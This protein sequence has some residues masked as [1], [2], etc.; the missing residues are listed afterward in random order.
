M[1]SNSSKGKQHQDTSQY[2]EIYLQTDKTAYYAGETVTGTIFLNMISHY[3]GNQLFLQF[4]GTEATHI[5]KQEQRGDHQENIK[6]SNKNKIIKQSLLVHSWE[7]LS[8]GQFSIPFSFLLPLHLPPSFYQQGHRYFAFLEYQLEAF[9]Q[10]HQDTDPRMKYKQPITLREKILPKTGDLPSH[11]TTQLK[12]C[13]CCKQ[14]SNF[15]KADFEKNFYSPGENAQAIMELNNSGTKLKNLKVV[16]A[17]KQRLELKAKG[18]ILKNVLVKVQQELPGIIKGSN[19]NA[20]TLTIVLPRFPTEMDFQR[21]V[22]RKKPSKSTL[23]KFKENREV[24]TSTTKS[25][26][27]TSTFFLEVSCP[28]NGCCSTLPKAQCPI[29]I[30]SPDFQLP[31]VTAPQNW[32]PVAL[33]NINLVFPPY[34]NDMKEPLLSKN[35]NEN[36]VEA[37]MLG[38]NVPNHQVSLEMTQAQ[39][40]NYHQ[41][42]QADGQINQIYST[43]PVHHTANSQ[44]NQ[45]Y[46][47]SFK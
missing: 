27:I 20:G 12:T 36:M 10:P 13:G 11:V 47:Q 32:Q 37:Q 19:T 46:F 40:L 1:G 31:V 16:L 4:K 17:L 6:Y 3:P 24:I 14:G 33:D 28:M 44:Y 7:T 34:E 41:E 42:N 18:R 23:L 5:V 45:N 39:S 22:D 29:G 9:L 38:N 2:G 21:D 43:N 15:L 8:T 25:S 30:Y 35:P 26:L